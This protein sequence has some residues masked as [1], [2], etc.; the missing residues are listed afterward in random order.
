MPALARLLKTDLNTLLSFHD[1]LTDIEIK[2]FVNLV[3]KVVQNQNYE[4]AFQIAIGKIQEYPTCDKLIYSL[5]LYLDGALFL[6]HVPGAERYK[7]VFETFYQRLAASEIQEIRDT[8]VGML[9]SYA[10]NR[11]EFSK[12]EE[13]I[14]ALPSSA[15]EKEEQLAILYQQQKKYEDAEKIWEHR[16]LKGV[17]VIQTALI[18]ML[19]TALLEKRD[20]DAEFF[21]DLYASVT[22][23]FCLPEWMLYNAYLLIALDRKNKEECLS[24]LRKMLP[25]MRK[26]WNPQR[27]RLYRSAESGVGFLSGKLADT[28][29]GELACKEEYSFLNN[30]AEFKELI[31]QISG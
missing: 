17:T 14:N 18:N 30:C 11:G 27:Y 19:E 24:I 13:F 26:E 4:A 12:A 20:G 31:A 16:V 15:I 28:L 21:A 8:A 2:N 5:I 3:D 9:I 7:E 10:R 23:D 1:D 22:R 25:A 29:C 6:Y